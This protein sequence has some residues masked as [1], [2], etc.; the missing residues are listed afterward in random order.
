M[1][2]VFDKG[3]LS[4]N[5][6]VSPFGDKY[7]TSAVL[8]DFPQTYSI[9]MGRPPEKVRID[10]SNIHVT[11]VPPVPVGKRAKTKPEHRRPAAKRR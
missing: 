9:V 10:V 3:G 5:G 8:A 4:F 6:A 2:S 1:F 7:L 11:I